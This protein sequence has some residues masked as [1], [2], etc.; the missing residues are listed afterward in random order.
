MGNYTECYP[1]YV[2]QTVLRPEEVER[3]LAPFRE[4]FLSQKEYEDV[5]MRKAVLIVY[6]IV[7]YRGTLKE[8][9]YETPFFLIYQPAGGFILNDFLYRGPD[10]RNR[11]T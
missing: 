11:S 8:P 6:G 5:R 3:Q 4:A 7:Y 9:T 2:K 1:L 10:E